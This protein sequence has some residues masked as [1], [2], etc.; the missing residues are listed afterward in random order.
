MSNSEIYDPSNSDL[1]SDEYATE[2]DDDALMDA[3]VSKQPPPPK[4]TQSSLESSS[5]PE[6][7]NTDVLESTKPPDS[8]VELPLPPT[9]TPAPNDKGTKPPATREE[10]LRRIKQIRA[11]KKNIGYYKLRSVRWLRKL[12]QFPKS[13]LEALKQVFPLYKA[14]YKRLADYWS[15]RAAY[16][17]KLLAR[18]S[19]STSSRSRSYSQS[20]S[21]SR[22]RSRFRSRS[23]SRSRSESN[24]PELICLDDT[25]NEDSPEKVE[26]AQTARQ[27][28]A[29]KEDKEKSIPLRQIEFDKKPPPLAPE[30]GS[31][32]DEFLTMK[33]PL[34][35]ILKQQ[36]DKEIT[37]Y[38]LAQF[39]AAMKQLTENTQQQPKEETPTT[40]APTEPLKRRRSV[41]PPPLTS[42]QEKRP[43]QMPDPDDDDDDYDRIE[44]IP[45][46]QPAQESPNRALVT[47]QQYVQPQ[48]QRPQQSPVQEKPQQQQ[49]Q[50]PLK[51][52]PQQPQQQQQTPP[53]IQTQIQKRKPQHPQQHHPLQPQVPQPHSQPLQPKP[54]KLQP[55]PKMQHLQSQHPQNQQPQQQQPQQTLQQ[56]PLQDP[57]FP[58]FQLGTP[59]SLAPVAGSGSGAI[60]QAV[61]LTAMAYSVNTPSPQ[62]VPMEISYTTAKLPQT[63]ANPMNLQMPT[64]AHQPRAT[65]PASPQPQIQPQAQTFAVPQQPKPRRSET[66]STQTPKTAQAPQPAAQNQIPSTAQNPPLGRP[67]PPLMDLG[68]DDANFHYHLLS[69]Y[70]EMDTQLK[71]K[72]SLVKPELKALAKERERI[73]FEMK[74]LDRQILKHE[75]EGNRLQYLRLVQNELRIRLERKERLAIIKSIVPNLIGQNCSISELSEMQ[76]MLALNTEDAAAVSMERC[77]NKMEQNRSNIEVLRSALGLKAPEREPT[78]SPTHRQAPRQMEE[79]PQNRSRNS[80]PALRGS[81]HVIN[82]FFDSR[83]HSEERTAPSSNLG[84][85]SS[86]TQNSQRLPKSPSLE[87]L[88]G[89]QGQVQAQVQISPHHR[90]QSSLHC[91]SGIENLM[92]PLYNSSPL[93]GQQKKHDE[94]HSNYNNESY[95]S[96]GQQPQTNTQPQ[97]IAKTFDNRGNRLQT[98]GPG[99]GVIILNGQGGEH[100]C[101]ECGKNEA[102]FICGICK[103]QCYCSRECQLRAWDEHY[104]LCGQ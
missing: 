66:V 52:K 87:F 73:E 47:P 39:S 72:I 88:T 41:T 74:N 84:H 32:L 3:A 21:N 102:N 12:H 62:A 55:D 15:D 63:A 36:V 44:F 85:I 67:K 86:Q 68:N 2:E 8:S 103:M 75:E 22:S 30:N 95:S 50:Q 24:S 80:L 5:M 90:S 58:V 59:Y 92:M 46:V 100:N 38:E 31:V 78:A 77:L 33:P 49:L 82:N 69:L 28:S 53:Q 4:E 11:R 56:K 94:M 71:A 79:F 83:R 43:R 60:Q 19:C 29:V 48:M 104:P 7:A 26:P 17:Q 57:R 13:K 6:K 93:A 81:T 37:A 97:G 27:M 65:P 20:R 1:S 99:E 51:D 10:T 101:M 23:G 76:A 9:P 34:N 70:E 64:Q 40:V 89:K 14:H 96:G 35:Q 45:V 98:S 18:Q 54:Q 91:P 42:S 16:R 61:N 25:E